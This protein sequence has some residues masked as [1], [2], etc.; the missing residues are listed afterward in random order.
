[1]FFV[2]NCLTLFTVLPFFVL[3][4]SLLVP[5][6]NSY[7]QDFILPSLPK[8]RSSPVPRSMSFLDRRLGRSRCWD[9]VLDRATYG[10]RDF[11][12]ATQYSRRLFPLSPYSTTTSPVVLGRYVPKPPVSFL[13][14]NIRFKLP[15]KTFYTSLHCTRLRDRT[16]Y[17]LSSPRS[18]FISGTFYNS[19]KYRVI[20]VT[21]LWRVPTSQFDLPSFPGAF[22][23][24]SSPPVKTSI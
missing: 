12:L 19:T 1:M 5:S 9:S 16:T 4:H 17:F 22:H 2:F 10:V 18:Y 6:P 13:L 24:D 11:P 7:S 8:S 14:P 15:Y 20:R 3:R 23:I 21:R